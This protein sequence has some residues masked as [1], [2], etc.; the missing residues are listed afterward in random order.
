MPL[1]CAT[2]REGFQ[3]KDKSEDL[4]EFYNSQ[5]SEKKQRMDGL[6][7]LSIFL[8]PWSHYFF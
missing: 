1:R 8:F 4:P 6:K 3:N 7:V 2:M 5:L